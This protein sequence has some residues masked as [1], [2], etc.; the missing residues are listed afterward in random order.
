MGDAFFGCLSGGDPLRMNGPVST[1][2]E[3]MDR[4]IDFDFNFYAWRLSC[5][6]P[7]S[8]LRSC[9]SSLGPR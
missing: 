3:M 9:G 1:P 2:A 7:P 5:T 4:I 6:R 8:G